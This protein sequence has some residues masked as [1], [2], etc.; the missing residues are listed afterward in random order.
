M[1]DYFASIIS[2][3][4]LGVTRGVLTLEPL[5]EAI[6]EKV[7][8]LISTSDKRGARGNENIPML[9]PVTPNKTNEILLFS[10]EMDKAPP[11]TPVFIDQEQ[12]YYLYQERCAIKQFD[13]NLTQQEAKLLAYQE[14]LKSFIE[15]LYPLIRDQFEHIILQPILH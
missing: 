3:E 13:G 5:K 11:V 10:A 1:K 15:N 14:T 8:P 12:F 4:L 7:I 9:P 6:D 2:P